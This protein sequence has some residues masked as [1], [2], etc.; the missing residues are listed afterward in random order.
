MRRRGFSPLAG[1]G[2]AKSSFY[3]SLICGSLERANLCAS[4]EPTE[5]ELSTAVVDDVATEKA[6]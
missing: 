4:R 5:L 3:I 1:R 6:S 2:D